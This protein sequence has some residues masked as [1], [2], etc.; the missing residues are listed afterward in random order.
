MSCHN[1]IAFFN[2]DATGG[3]RG[4]VEFH[5]CNHYAV[6]S[7]CMVRFNLSGFRPNKTHAIHIHE[8]GDERDG[9][10]SL[11]GHFNPTNTTHGSLDIN[12]ESHV[13]DLI[14]NLF[15]DEEG[16]FKF[17]YFDP[18]LRIEGYIDNSIIGRSVVIHEGIDDLGLGGIEP[19]NQKIRCESLK[20]GNAGK[21]MACAII[22]LA[23]NGKWQ[24][25]TH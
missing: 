11:G 6:D 4:T 25:T 20:T 18:R 7:G 14:N 10:T 21:R 8:F 23:K 13:G 2:A 1:A 16:F 22:G 19:Y 17:E 3:V 5:E 9:C 12:M 15:T 24:S